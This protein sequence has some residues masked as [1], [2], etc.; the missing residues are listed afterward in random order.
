VIIEEGRLVLFGIPC[1]IISA[2]T[3]NGGEAMNPAKNILC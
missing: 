1:I 3:L 2:A